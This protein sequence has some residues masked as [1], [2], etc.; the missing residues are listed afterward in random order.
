MVFF[1]KFI[2]TFQK[3]IGFFLQK[4]HNK[5][6]TDK[7]SIVPDPSMVFSP[8]FQSSGSNEH[9][10]KVSSK[11]GAGFL[12]K[13]NISV[14]YLFTKNVLGI[15]FFCFWSDFDETLWDCSTHQM[16]W[17]KWTF[18]QSFI[19]IGLKTKKNLFLGPDIKLNKFF[20]TS[21]EMK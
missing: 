18:S 16:N 19:E 7:K 8:N 4:N 20:S 12:R 5:E 3:F 21:S 11:S 2:R 1:G 6:K 14:S 9:S 13:L 17:I 10:Q 15:K